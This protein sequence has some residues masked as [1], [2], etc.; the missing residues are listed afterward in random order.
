LSKGGWLNREKGPQSRKQSRVFY[1]DYIQAINTNL[2]WLG[3]VDKYARG[4]ANESLSIRAVSFLA[5]ASHGSQHLAD[6]A[7][8][9][10]VR[11]YD[12][13]PSKAEVLVDFETKQRVA[14][15]PPQTHPVEKLLVLEKF[16]GQWFITEDFDRSERFNEWINQEWSAKRAY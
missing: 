7:S 9:I 1:K 5:D 11:F 14:G 16:D 8:P 6:I 4:R 10:T 15:N 2:N 12:F 13:A 3:L